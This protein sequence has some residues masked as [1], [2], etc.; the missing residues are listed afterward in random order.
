MLQS[1]RVFVR[2]AQATAIC[3]D[4]LWQMDIYSIREKPDVYV[5]LFL[6][7]CVRV[8]LCVCVCLCVGGLYAC[9]G[10]CACVCVYVCARAH[11]ICEQAID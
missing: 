4:T 6:S 7:I 11:F 2:S 1:L 9:V 8:C 5:S 10:V 3:Y